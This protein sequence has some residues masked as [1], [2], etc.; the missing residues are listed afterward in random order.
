MRYFWNRGWLR[1]E[2]SILVNRLTRKIGGMFVSRADPTI[3][4]GM[5]CSKIPDYG[6]TH[7][8]EDA[9]SERSQDIVSLTKVPVVVFS[10]GV[11]S[12]LAAASLADSHGDQVTIGATTSAIECAPLELMNY[13]K[14]MGCK[15]EKA[16][17]G[18]FRDV[19]E[20]G[21]KL[22]TGCMGDN[23]VLG[24]YLLEYGLESTIFD[25]SRKEFFEHLTGSSDGNK[26]WEIYRRLFE[27]MP[28]EIPRTPPNLIW[29]LSFCYGWVRDDLNITVCTGLGAPGREILHFF[30]SVPFQKLMM[31]DHALKGCNHA[32]KRKVQ[33]VE[34]ISKITKRDIEFPNH[35]SAGWEDILD[36]GTTLSN[37]FSI[38][39]NWNTRRLENGNHLQRF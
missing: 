38:D 13:F 10:G 22:V 19:I 30:D 6:V 25:I 26:D 1:S 36:E 5:M 3:S 29:W 9:A 20:N 16:D 31:R 4:R 37:I 14:E 17:K 28:K 12:A 24:N 32:Q 21:G 34:A 8:I 23:M 35:K 11:D 39:E 27:N 2:D 18:W 7:T 15:V 33:M